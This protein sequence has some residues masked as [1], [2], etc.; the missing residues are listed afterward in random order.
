M[1]KIVLIFLYLFAFVLSNAQSPTLQWV[2]S[3][4]GNSDDDP[5][6]IAVDGLGNVYT[7]GTFYGD[8]IDLDPGPGTFTLGSA[9]D[10]DIFISKLDASGNF[11]WGKRIGGIFAD[12]VNSFTLDISGNVYVTG[13]F[14][15]VVDFNP[16]PGV[17]NLTETGPYGSGDIFILKLDV[18]GNFVW[19]KKIGGSSSDMSRDI[20]LDPVGNVYTTGYFSNTVDFD[21]G[22]GIFNLTSGG[23]LSI[24]VSKLDPSGNYVWA[25]NMFGTSGSIGESIAIDPTGNVCTTG[26][27]S[28]IVDFDPG[29][30]TYTLASGAGMNIFVSKLDVSG[31][32]VWAKSFYGMAG[33]NDSRSI[34]IDGLGNVFTTGEFGGTVDFDPGIA[35]YS[36]TVAGQG[37]IFISKLDASGNFVWAKSMGG[38]LIEIANSIALDASGNVY[39]TGEY[40]GTCDF[41]PGVGTFTMTGIN[42]DAF[43]SKLDA[44][45][46][47][48]WAENLGGTF[49]DE[50]RSITLDASGNIY[51]TGDYEGICDFDPGA[52]V[53]NSTT[54]GLDDCYVHKM[55]QGGVGI[56]ENILPSK[57]TVF[58]NPTTGKVTLSFENGIENALLKLINVTGQTIVERMEINS[59]KFTIDI[60]DLT[61][62]IYLLEIN[63]GLTLYRSK[64]VKN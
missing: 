34:A 23:S 4:G 15:G 29:I 51:T 35:N 45:G 62:G 33:G 16:G 41:D 59:K 53:Y 11:V 58:P 63:D 13:S 61:S 9:G 44:A 1:K 55:S 40:E 21:P 31:N 52:G 30:G 12:Y 48:V 38:P 32:F 36:L 6:C 43:I 8:T 47:F 18:S 27:F 56:E 5:S 28:G 39:T 54:V 60:S 3:L 64:I 14:E 19:A 37:D 49:I 22:A 20:V 46:N 10:L 17:F 25:K 2:K 57:F 24:F 7:S 42:Y 50:G 26:S